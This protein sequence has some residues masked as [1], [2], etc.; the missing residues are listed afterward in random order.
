MASKSKGDEHHGYHRNFH[1]HGERL[2][3]HHTLL[4][5]TASVAIDPVHDKRGEKSPDYRVHCLS[6]GPGEIGAAWKRQGDNGEY[7]SVRIDD[8]SFPAPINCRLV[9]T[10]TE[11]NYSLIWERQRHRGCRIRFAILRPL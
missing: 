11:K 6:S 9:K 4:T 8:P 7:L 5:F 3:R 1:T 2:H 10:G